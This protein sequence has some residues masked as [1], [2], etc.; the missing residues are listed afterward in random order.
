MGYY[1]P[2]GDGCLLT[3]FMPQE[4]KNIFLN[5]LAI[6]AFYGIL[7]FFVLAVIGILTIK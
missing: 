4:Q 7:I 3:M 5:I 6:L 2:D 1:E